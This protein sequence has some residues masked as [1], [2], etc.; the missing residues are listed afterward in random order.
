MKKQPIYEGISFVDS[1]C[2]EIVRRS[3]KRR[4]IVSFVKHN[5]SDLN[6]DKYFKVSIDTISGLNFPTLSGFI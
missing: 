2:D 5:K 6:P 4:F 3:L 1:L